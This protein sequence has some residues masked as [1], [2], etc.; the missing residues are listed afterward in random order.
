MVF[1]RFTPNLSS[2]TDAKRCEHHKYQ[3]GIRYTEKCGEPTYF[4][5]LGRKRTHSINWQWLFSVLQTISGKILTSL[6]AAIFRS[7]ATS[8]ATFGSDPS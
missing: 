5:Y 1:H 4:L 2:K 3:W 8:L 6:A 7:R